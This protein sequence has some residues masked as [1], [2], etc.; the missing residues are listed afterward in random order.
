VATNKKR[1]A[2]EWLIFVVSF[3]PGTF[4]VIFASFADGRMAPLW[5]WALFPF[6]PYFAILP[7]RSIVW[8]VR[9]LRH[10]PNENE[11]NHAA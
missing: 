7:V 2:K 9:T 3:L 8:S 11:H 5:A 6:G 10:K 1:L 4:F